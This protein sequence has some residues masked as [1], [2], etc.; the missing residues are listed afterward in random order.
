M[1]LRRVLICFASLLRLVYSLMSRIC[2]RARHLHGHGRN[3][4]SPVFL[5]YS[6]SC[7]TFIHYVT[8]LFDEQAPEWHYCRWPVLRMRPYF[9]RTLV[10]GATLDQA[11]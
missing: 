4:L 10:S 11:P 3:S 9:G 6:H 7:C 8:V 1:Y 5:M 2:I